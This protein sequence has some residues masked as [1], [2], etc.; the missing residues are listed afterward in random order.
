[1]RAAIE[2]RG[3]VNRFGHQVVHDGLDADIRAFFDC[4]SHAWMMRFLEHRIGDRRVL[5]LIAKWLKAGVMEE[6]VTFPPVSGPLR[7][8]IFRP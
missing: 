1:M 7:A 3:I 6:G 4:I 2:V 8:G 5:R